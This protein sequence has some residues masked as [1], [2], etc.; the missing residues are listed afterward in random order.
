MAYAKTI[1]IKL[2]RSD[3][4]LT[5]KAKIYNA[6][7][8]QQGSDV[9]A[10]FSELGGGEY[11]WSYAS[12]ADGFAGRVDFYSGSTFE[13]STGVNPSQVDLSGVLSETPTAGTVGEALLYA[14]AVGQYKLSVAGTTMTL[15]KANGTDVLKTWTLNSATNPTSRTPA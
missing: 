14:L 11:A 12:F 7:G 3:T 9:T 5:L 8:V 15:Y 2:G 6:A 13:T 10:G 4:G 1:I